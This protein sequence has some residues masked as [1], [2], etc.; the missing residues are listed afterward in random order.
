MFLMLLMVDGGARCDP[1]IICL[2]SI[3]RRPPERWSRISRLY[4]TT[5]HSSTWKFTFWPAKQNHHT[6][7]SRRR[8]RRPLQ[9]WHHGLRRTKT[10]RTLVL[11]DHP[12]IRSRRLG[13]W[14]FQARFH[15]GIS[16]LAR[17][18]CYFGCGM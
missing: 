1:S 7:H 10:R 18:C 12:S 4:R 17:R 3:D 6:T 14:I 9:H 2:L 11:L 15:G 8:P 5:K 13:D 16:I